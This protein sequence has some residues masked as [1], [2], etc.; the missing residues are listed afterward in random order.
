M[1]VRLGSSR[2]L[3]SSSSLRSLLDL[4][5]KK[6]FGNAVDSLTGSFNLLGGLLDVELLIGPQRLLHIILLANTNEATLSSPI[7]GSL[8]VETSPDLIDSLNKLVT[9]LL[10]VSGSWGYAETLLANRNRRVIDSL[11]IDS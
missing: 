4:K 10:D 7:R 8:D 5:L 1:S 11:D 2:R 6:S 3:S 9:V